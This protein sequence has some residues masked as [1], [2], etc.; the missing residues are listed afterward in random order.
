MNGITKA[1]SESCLL[2]DWWEGINELSLWSS[3]TGGHTLRSGHQSYDRDCNF[4]T[5]GQDNAVYLVVG[6]AKSI[7]IDIHSWTYI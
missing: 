6:A 1:P 5:C 3:Y 4:S 7:S 2:I